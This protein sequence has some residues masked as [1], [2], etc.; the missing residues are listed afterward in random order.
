[1][2]SYSTAITT[3][4]DNRVQLDSTG[5]GKFVAPNAIS[6]DPGSFAISTGDFSGVSFTAESLAMGM[7]GSDVLSLL[8][9]QG[10]LATEQIQAVTDYS[11]S[12]ISAVTENKATELAT[13]SGEP[14][15]SKYIPYLL[16][17]GL[18]LLFWRKRA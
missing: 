15:W 17:A 10:S 12:A 5:G 18:A 1:M 14:T 6:T 13:A 7:S 11:A 4:Q 3:S 9:Q 8:Q 2:G 16:A